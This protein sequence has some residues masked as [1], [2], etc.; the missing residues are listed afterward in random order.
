MLPG[1]PASD[2][3]RRIEQ[4]ISDF[5]RRTPGSGNTPPQIKWTGFSCEGFVLE[6]GSDA[7]KTLAAAHQAIHG[8][9]IQESVMPAYLDARV[10][11]LYDKIPTLVYGPGG[12]NIHSIDEAVE[13]ETIKQ[14]TKS[15]ALF[16]ARWC[17]LAPLKGP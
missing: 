14:A 13:L 8:S 17:G 12:R 5:S 15:I 11:I 10:T 3:K 16:T 4:T 9:P 6:P 7:E 2:L 1:V